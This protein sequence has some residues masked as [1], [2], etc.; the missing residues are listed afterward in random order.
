MRHP[1][2]IRFLLMLAFLLVDLLFLQQ[3]RGV[4]LYVSSLFVLGVGIALVH[5]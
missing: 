2:L 1:R 3:Y 4:A 5:P